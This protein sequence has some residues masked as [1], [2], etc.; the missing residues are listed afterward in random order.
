VSLSSLDDKP[1]VG[2]GRA[3]GLSRRNFLRE[4]RRR[5]R[6][7]RGLRG[8]AS[9]SARSASLKDPDRN[10]GMTLEQIH[11]MAD[12]PLVGWA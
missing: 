5:W 10:G 7:L 1:E 11:Q 8:S 6:T 4:R 2:E 12:D 9:P 3:G